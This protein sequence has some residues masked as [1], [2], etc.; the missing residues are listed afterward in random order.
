[1]LATGF[2]GDAGVSGAGG[3]GVQAGDEGAVR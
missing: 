2:P 1:M 3:K